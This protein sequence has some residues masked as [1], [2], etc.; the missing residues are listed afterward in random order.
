MSGQARFSGVYPPI[1]TPFDDDGE[2]SVAGLRSNVERW[3]KT[4][5]TGL[6]VLG[7]NG[8]FPYLDDDERDL[9]VSTVMEAAPPNLKIVVGAGRESTRATIK[10]VKR[11]AELGA[12]AAIVINPSYYT[13]A[14]TDA[15]LFEHYRA[16]ALE[17]PIPILLYNVPPYTGVNMSASLVARLAAVPNVVGVKDTSA[18]IVQIAETVRITPPD[19]ATLAG[20]ASFLLAS[21]AVGAAGGVLAVANLAPDECVTLVKAFEAGKWTEALQIQQLLL[22]VNAAVTTRFGAAGLKA[23]MELRGYHGGLPR[24]PL[25]PLSSESREEIKKI[26]ETASLLG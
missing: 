20:S 15:V 8:E 17:S 6:V 18:N 11:V 5:L 2:V 3:G 10:T 16:V 9:V 26:L 1:A 12:H 13:G 21:L 23:A 19:F 4:G 7:S 14:M 22:P 25:Q 24:R